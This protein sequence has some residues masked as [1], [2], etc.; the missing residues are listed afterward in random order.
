[1]NLSAQTTD[2]FFNL[3]LNHNSFS[4]RLF[5]LEKGLVVKPKSG[6]YL[7]NIPVNSEILSRSFIYLNYNIQ[8]NVHSIISLV[9]QH[10]HVLLTTLFGLYFEFVLL[11][12]EHL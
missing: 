11:A 8:Y 5:Y 3:P 7:T 6:M 1:M 4:F 12:V 2:S 9:Q 10:S